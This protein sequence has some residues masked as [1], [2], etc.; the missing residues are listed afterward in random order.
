MSV[1][2][3]LARAN[4]VFRTDEKPIRSENRVIDKNDSDLG[5]ILYKNRNMAG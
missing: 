2:C 4:P 3:A 5:L 1:H